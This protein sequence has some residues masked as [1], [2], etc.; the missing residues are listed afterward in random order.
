[1]QKIII[2]LVPIEILSERINFALEHDLPI[3]Y[4]PDSSRVKTGVRSVTHALKERLSPPCAP[5]S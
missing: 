2:Q 5:L 4:L 3:V 1:M